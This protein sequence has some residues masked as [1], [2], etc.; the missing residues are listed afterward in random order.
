MKGFAQGHRASQ[1]WGEV[2]PNPL[3]SPS[4]SPKEETSGTGPLATRLNPEMSKLPPRNRPG[5]LGLS[6]D[7]GA[8]S[9]HC[10]QDWLIPH[11][12][13]PQLSLDK[14][15]M[16]TFALQSGGSISVSVTLSPQ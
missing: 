14:R 9:L 5:S 3:L 2:T 6:W 8:G 10:S 15:L 4:T 13:F 16:P 11:R 1:G 7:N 12:S